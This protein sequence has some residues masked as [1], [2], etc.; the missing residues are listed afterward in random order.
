MFCPQ[1]KAEYREGFKQCTNCG[2]DL[3]DQ[4]APEPAEEI[5]SHE[6][7]DYV[8][9]ST[10]Q[11]PFEEEQ[12]CSFLNANGIPARIQGEA[13]RRTYGFTMDGLGAGNI[14]VPRDM[15]AAAQDLLAKAD[16]GD[17]RIEDT[18]S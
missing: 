8:V 11:G 5:F 14:L 3:V 16:R 2:V 18:E 12:V 13:V 17:L 15:A 7:P 4:L 10:V 1:C 9:V 6:L